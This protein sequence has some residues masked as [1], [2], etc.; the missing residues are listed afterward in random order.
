[1]W[2]IC[3]L[4]LNVVLIASGENPPQRTV[5][6][7]QA[8]I[9]AYML[10]NEGVALTAQGNIAAAV[11][12]YIAA[13]ALKENLFDAHL[14]AGLLLGR[15]LGD[16]DQGIS[17]LQVCVEDF[18]RWFIVTAHHQAIATACEVAMRS[19][20]DVSLLIML[21]APFAL[22]MLQAALS[23]PNI[24]DITRAALLGAIGHLMHH[25]FGRDVAMLQEALQYIERYISMSLSSI[26]NCHL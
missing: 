24:P 22:C 17:T 7:K 21:C 10:Y 13:I 6:V 14:N 2:L 9:P 19:M 8:D 1:M 11:Q 16:Y 12:Q 23:S 5:H 4:W 25:N 26:V 15:E 20:A 18:C 3:L